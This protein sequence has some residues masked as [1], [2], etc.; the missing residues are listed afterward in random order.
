M[1]LLC[2]IIFYVVVYTIWL[3]PRTDQNIVIG[4]AAGALPPLVGWVSVTGTVNVEPCLLF[5]LIFF[6]TPPHFWSLAMVCGEDYKKIKLPMMP[7]TRGRYYTSFQ[8]FCYTILVLFVSI[9]FY[10]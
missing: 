1:G 4:G 6:W 2:T 7:H 8:G 3:K 5:L 10:I 9:S